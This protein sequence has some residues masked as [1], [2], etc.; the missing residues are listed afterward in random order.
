M[1]FQI[2]SYVLNITW[3][4]NIWQILGPNSA[5]P[6]CFAHSAH[7]IATQLAQNSSP[8]PKKITFQPVTWLWY[9]Q[10]KHTTSKNAGL[11]DCYDIRSGN[12][13]GLF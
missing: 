12:T 1:I 13:S 7:P 3:K 8:P 4:N 9:Q 11:V 10:S 2:Y 6:V 5:G